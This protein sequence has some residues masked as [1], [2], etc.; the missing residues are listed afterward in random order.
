M[1]F[2]R[3]QLIVS[4]MLLNRHKPVCDLN[5]FVVFADCIHVHLKCYYVLLVDNKHMCVLNL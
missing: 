1:T 5:M 3:I 2:Y 4:K